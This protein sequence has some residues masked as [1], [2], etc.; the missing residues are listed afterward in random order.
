MIIALS[1]FLLA[2]GLALVVKCADWFVDASVTMAHTLR[3]PPMIIG[4]T[5]VSI[6][7]TLPEIITSVTS[8]IMGNITGNTADYNAIAI[9]NAIGSMA[10]NLG[11]ILAISLIARSG[12]TDKSYNAKA[13]LLI[14][15]SSLLTLFVATSRKI[16]IYEGIILLLLFVAFVAMNII[17]AV[18]HMRSSNNMD[19]NI[20]SLPTSTIDNAQL[21]T[22]TAAIRDK[23]P[24][25]LAIKLTVQFIIG[26][27]G[28]ALGAYLMVNNA[29]RLCSLAGIPTQI[30]GATVIAIGTSLPEFATAIAAIV[31]GESSLS[32]GNLIGANVINGTLLL[33]SITLIG[34][35]IPVDNYT[36]SFG[37][38]FMLAIAAIA[39][40]PTVFRGKTSK[41]QGVL[42][43]MTYLAMII[44]NIVY[45]I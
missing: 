26:G 38:I 23:M 30:I 4:A 39:I 28:I 14:A 16:E 20:I 19:I 24:R 37:I 45:I 33:G 27:V 35:G 8:V 17:Q 11:L 12:K 41:L 29:S 40:L 18:K 32:M 36:A 25:S 9:G 21:A 7:T 2:V 5:I 1:L 34:G 13:V 10:C 31:K 22:A 6:G 44:T 3:I 15:I 43:L 42:L